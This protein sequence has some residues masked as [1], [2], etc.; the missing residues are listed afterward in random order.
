MRKP[1]FAGCLALMV[2]L[3]FSSL[4]AANAG[5]AKLKYKDKE[6]PVAINFP[7]P[8]KS[9]Y[10]VL[11]NLS[12]IYAFTAEDKASSQAYAIT[13]TFFPDSLGEITKQVGQELVSQS[14]EVQI[15]TVNASLGTESRILKENSVPLAG[16]PSKYITLVRD[17]NPKF[18]SCYRGVFLNR[19]LVTSW[20]T[21]F[22]VQK[23]RNLATVFI[24]SL[25][26]GK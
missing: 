26:L 16:Y 9:S 19:L 14:L 15:D 17:T 25:K 22:D 18:F 12:E 4:T 3:L 20:S 6:F 24:E 13:I 11:P 1:F 23:N 7:V 21:G 5:I 8:A 2:F 10:R